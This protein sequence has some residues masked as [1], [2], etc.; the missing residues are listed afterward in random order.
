MQRVLF[1]H[2][3]SPGLRARLAALAGAGLEV[4]IVP[5]ADRARL[6][7]E[8]PRTEVL[9]HVLEPVTEELLARAPRLR[10][11]QKIGVGVNTIDLEACRVRG[12]AVCNMP[13]TN[14]R[15]VAELALG[16]MLAVLRR[17][18]FLDRATR[19]GRGWELP[20]DLPDRVGELGGKRVGLL[21]MGAVPRLLAPALAALGAE[22][23]YWNRS[24]KPDAPARFLPLEELLATSDVVSLHLP[25][26]PE[27]RGLLSAE[28]IARMKRGAILINTARGGLV[29]ERALLAALERGHLA[30]A[31]LDVFEVEPLPPD[32]PLLRREEVVATPH[33]AWLT[34][35]TLDRSLSV[36]V[37][38][39]RRLA[40]GEALLNRVV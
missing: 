15:A 23:V 31:G 10:L 38:N 5:A 40:R 25:L 13:G 36:A 33:L 28:R 18:P 39:C 17:I 22:C 1:H 20:E 9:W 34:P 32:H 8:L 16:L 26:V 21:G 37:E 35:E 24:V 7:V 19:A 11:V 2:E 30:G 29:D 12:I 27:T 14:S 4:A 3:A 6:A